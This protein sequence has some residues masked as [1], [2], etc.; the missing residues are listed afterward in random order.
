MGNAMTDSNDVDPEFIDLDD[1]DPEAEEDETHTGTSPELLAVVKAKMA[2]LRRMYITSGRDSSLSVQFERL[3]EERDFGSPER[4]WGGLLVKAPSG[5]GKS[6]LVREFLERHPRVIGFG[7]DESN[8]SYVQVPSPVT[9]RTLGTAV[10]RTM[11]PQQRENDQR[12]ISAEDTLS[13]IWFETRNL[14]EQLEIMGLWIDEGHDLAAAGAAQLQVLQLTFKR[15]L[16]HAHQPILI[17]SGTMEVEDVFQTRELRRRFLDVDI[18]SISAA[19]DAAELRRVIAKYLR[20]AGLGIDR[21]LNHIV[22][23]L[24][25]AGT[26]QL[27]WTCDVILEAIR[28]ALLDQSD[29]LSIEHFARSYASIVGCS[30]NDNPF[31]AQDW[32]GIDTVLQRARATPPDDPKPKR[33]RR[34]RKDTQW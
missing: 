11:Y 32:A 17:L 19:E 13:D 20:T 4:R 33:R 8:F 9:N 28:V 31:I 23:R 6:R 30:D 3:M 22:G 27:G 14:A 26:H 24:V 5:A 18:P 21:S 2:E 10:L 12:K 34:R 16:G 25:H 7:T 15:W 1:W 29:R